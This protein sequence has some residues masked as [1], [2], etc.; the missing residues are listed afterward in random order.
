[1]S[2]LCDYAWFGNVRQIEHAVEMAVA[3]TGTRC[4]LTFEDF[5]LQETPSKS[6]VLDV[7]VPPCGIHFDQTVQHLERSLIQQALQI[8]KGNR[9]RAADLLR[10]KRTTLLA[11]IKTLGLGDSKSEEAA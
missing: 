11:K 10:L 3:L 9:G 2:R 1:M 4:L 7:V 6:G 8:S 5:R